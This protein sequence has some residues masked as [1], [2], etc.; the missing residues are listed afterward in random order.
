MRALLPSMY[1]GAERALCVGLHLQV[2]TPD[3][4]HVL[5]ANEGFV[6]YDLHGGGNGSAHALSIDG[7]EPLLRLCRLL[8][9]RV[10]DHS[11]LLAR[12]DEWGDADEIIRESRDARRGVRQ[13]AEEEA[14]QR[15]TAERR[16]HAALAW[17]DS[18]LRPEDGTSKAVR[19][20]LYGSGYEPGEGDR[21][22]LGRAWYSEDG[23]VAE[24]VW[25][26]H[27]WRL[28]DG[29]EA[30][31]DVGF[32][33][34]TAFESRV[35]TDQPEVMATYEAILAQQLAEPGL[36]LDDG[37][38]WGAPRPA[39]TTQG[40]KAPAVQS[41]SL[42]ARPGDDEALTHYH[43]LATAV[44]A[45]SFASLAPL[46]KTLATCA[47]ITSA[48]SEDAKNRLI[49]FVARFVQGIPYSVPDA[50]RGGLRPPVN[51]LLYRLGD[52]DSKSLLLALLLKHLGV[53]AGLFVSF[54]AGHALAAVAAPTPTLCDK[55]TL[56]KLDCAEEV[57]AWAK[58]AGVATP[59]LWAAMPER[60]K[61]Q[62][63]GD[64]ASEAYELT[65]YVPVESTVYADV[66]SITTLREPQSWVFVPLC[67][68]W[69]KVGLVTLD[70]PRDS[71][72]ID[73]ARA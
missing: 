25:C 53:E 33:R 44:A 41:T 55:K 58:Q 26:K 57:A 15:A 67:A 72:E 30:A 27:R 46:A 48:E 9:E 68:V 65:L 60:P 56:A 21:C 4:N 69:Q 40:D 29:N 59:P 19:P 24:L 12:F 16:R 50:V 35:L 37:T 34:Q 1:R 45:H 66:G 49:S 2:P 39:F 31:L 23:S 7:P 18:R 11:R 51:T 38:V 47:G 43:T 36:A 17:L 22:D 52:C 70:L 10:I 42:A 14:L 64:S 6:V 73:G 71:S 8:I 32:D 20:S 61:P 63:G 5:A 54:A 62:I 13:G 28:K 3:P